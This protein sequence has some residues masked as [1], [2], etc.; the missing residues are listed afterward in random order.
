M[1]AVVQ[2]GSVYPGPEF[3]TPGKS[4][5]LCNVQNHTNPEIK[6]AVVTTSPVVRHDP[7]TGEIETLNTIY[8]PSS[9]APKPTS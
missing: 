1:K 2:Y 3:V 4:C 5:I 7:S 6:G 8:T 9:S